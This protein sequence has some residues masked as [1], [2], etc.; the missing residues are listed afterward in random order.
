MKLHKT[1]NNIPSNA[2]SAVI[3]TLN[4]R[5][6][7]SI[8]LALVTKQAHWNLRGKNFIGVHEMLDGF[9][10]QIDIY[11]DAI[12]ERVV[13]L[14]GTALGTSQTVV[15]GTKL[16][17][18]PLDISKVEDHLAALADRY[19]SVAND[20]R[21]AIDSTDEAGDSD[22][23]DILTNFSKE[24]DKALWFIEAHIEA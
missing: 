20:V 6:A 9:R 16:K 23:A 18:Y 4:A 24:L 1:R 19:G 11:T 7:E 8:D 15:E 22:S 2:R 14:G 10:A 5:L 21:A 17:P 13:Q 12:A 3:E